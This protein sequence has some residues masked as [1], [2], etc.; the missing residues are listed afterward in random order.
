MTS[1]RLFPLDLN[2]FQTS[3]AL[4]EHEMGRSSRF[5]TVT[6]ITLSLFCFFYKSGLIVSC[7]KLEI[8]NGFSKL[9][10]TFNETIDFSENFNYGCY[11]DGSNSW[12]T[13]RGPSQDIFDDLCKTLVKNYRCI[14]LDENMVGGEESEDA[15]DPEENSYA[16]VFSDFSQYPDFSQ[17]SDGFSISGSIDL[18]TIDQVKLTKQCQKLNSDKS[19]CQI[20]TCISDAVFVIEFYNLF[21]NEPLDQFLIDFKNNN[22]NSD[23]ICRSRNFQQETSFRSCCGRYPNRFPVSMHSLPAPNLTCTLNGQKYH[24]QNGNVN[25]CKRDNVYGNCEIYWSEESCQ[26]CLS[27]DIFCAGVT[28]RSKL[29]DLRNNLRQQNR[30]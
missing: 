14:V 1:N 30:N 29:K 16:S 24:A 9:S 27:N 7:F 4:S 25:T 12:K 3:R 5:P 21:K 15:C 19:N 8:L 11:C 6:L 13:L 22:E 10:E 18:A 2:K 23:E 17:Y 26:Q 28:A 20:N